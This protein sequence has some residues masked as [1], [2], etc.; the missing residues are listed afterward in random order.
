MPRNLTISYPDEHREYWF[1][2]QVFEP[3]DL[4]DRDAGSWIVVRVGVPNEAG[5]HTTAVVRAG[6]R[7]GTGPS[8]ALK[9]SP[10]R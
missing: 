5:K 8:K 10:S 3:G 7:T 4:L 1:T 6:V 2:D 9:L